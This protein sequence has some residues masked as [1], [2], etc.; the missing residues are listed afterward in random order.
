M[1]NG[2]KKQLAVLGSVCA[3]IVI[4]G[5]LIHSLLLERRVWIEEQRLQITK[6][7]ETVEVF[8]RTRT[9]RPNWEAETT[10]REKRILRTLPE[11]LDQGAFLTAIQ[12]KAVI[13]GLTIEKVTPGNQQNEGGLTTLPIALVCKGNYFQLVSFF[14]QIEERGRYVKIREVRI[15]SAE[16]GM[17]RCHLE[18]QIFAFAA[19]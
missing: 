19:V 16:A 13:A 8:A 11:S 3:L 1:R 2:E 9:S 14:R 10:A 12:R 5:F 4:V 18:M 6:Q 15:E 17:L 7:V